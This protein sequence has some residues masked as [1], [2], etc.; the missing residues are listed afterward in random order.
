M[1]KQV[2]SRI[3][4]VDWFHFKEI[5]RYLQR[6]CRPLDQRCL[7]LT[8]PPSTHHLLVSCCYGPHLC[9]NSQGEIV[10]VNIPES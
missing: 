2:I 5:N 8:I 4:P 6:Y 10:V 3:F 7:S 9:L 1:S